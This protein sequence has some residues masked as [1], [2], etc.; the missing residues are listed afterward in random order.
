MIEDDGEII[1]DDGALRR[2]VVN[3]EM[4]VREGQSVERLCGAGHRF[5][6]GAD[7]SIKDNR[8]RRPYDVTP[9]SRTEILQILE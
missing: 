4:T 5:D 7:K 8:G 1:I 6:S 2:F 9:K 3:L